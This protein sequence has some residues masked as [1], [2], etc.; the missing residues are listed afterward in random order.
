[1]DA[2]SRP[3]RTQEDEAV[4][5]KSTPWEVRVLSTLAHVVSIDLS[6]PGYV[7]KGDSVRYEH[8]GN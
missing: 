6:C 2:Q 5:V 4:E 8:I 7:P 3:R 1:M